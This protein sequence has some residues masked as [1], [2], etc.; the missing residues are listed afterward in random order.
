ME[1]PY[2]EIVRIMNASRKAVSTDQTQQYSI[3]PDQLFCSED[4]TFVEQEG[5]NRRTYYREFYSKGRPLLDTWTMSGGKAGSTIISS[6]QSGVPSRRFRRRYGRIKRH[7][8]DALMMRYHKIVELDV[9]DAEFGPSIYITAAVKG[10]P[11]RL[12]MPAGKAVQ[13]PFVIER[14]GV[15]SLKTE[16]RGVT[17][18]SLLELSTYTTGPE[19]KFIEF[20][21]NQSTQGSISSPAGGGIVVSPQ[22]PDHSF[23]TPRARVPIFLDRC[24]ELLHMLTLPVHFSAWLQMTTMSGDFAEWHELRDPFAPIESM[25]EGTVVGFHEGR[26]GLDTT[27]CKIIGVVSER[28]AVL[29]SSTKSDHPGVVVAYCGASA[30]CCNA[31]LRRSAL[32]V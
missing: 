18:A 2:A 28:P 13:A 10:V 7:D 25:C 23:V 3:R 6:G 31:P 26:V 27:G 8:G 17:N 11:E 19:A 1:F 29:G 32:F 20:K 12:V 24:I 14:N 15:K 5:F 9:N 30:L 16:G 22:L 21:K 4:S